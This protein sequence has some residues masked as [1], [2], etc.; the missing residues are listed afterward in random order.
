VIY[1]YLKDD[2]QI[3]VPV[4]VDNNITFASKSL[5]AIQS[6]IQELTQHFELCDLGPTKFLL[7]IEVIRDCLNHSISVSQCQYILDILDHFWLSDCHPVLTPIDPG[8][9]LDISDSPASAEDITFMQQVPYLSVVGT[10]MYLAVTTHQDIAY[11]VGVLARFSS[12]PGVAHWKAAKH[13]FCYLKGTI[14]LKL[15]YSP[16]SSGEL[17]TT[18]SDADHGGCR[19]SGQSTGGYL[20]KFGTGAISWHSKLLEWTS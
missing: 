11:A 1:V 9:Q 18:F 20:V 10:L 4:H 19:D 7:G 15:T 6:C 5:S 12:N 3:I 13:L 17:F 14:D 16:D 8:L 2:V